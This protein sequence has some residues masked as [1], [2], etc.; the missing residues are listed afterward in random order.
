MVEDNRELVQLLTK[1]LARAGLDVDWARTA[2]A[3]EA[4]LRAIHYAAVVL[5]LGLPDADGFSVLDQMRRRRDPTPVLILSARSGLGDRVTG[6]SKGASDYMVKPFATDELIARLQAL[7]RRE[8]AAG[9]KQLSFGNVSLDTENRQVAIADKP[10][11]LPGRAADVLEV[12]LKRSGHVVSHEQLSAQVFGG[13]QDIESNALEVYVYRLRK[14]LE[15]AGASVHIH[16]IRGA[17]YLLELKKS[18]G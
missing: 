18:G 8:S 9:G 10:V 6:L 13:A 1:S 16:T 14:V 11:F 3:A 15:D 12:L 4:S 17:G 2:D 5:D 7:I